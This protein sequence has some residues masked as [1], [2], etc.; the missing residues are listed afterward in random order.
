MTK[1]TYSEAV[2]QALNGKGS[3]ADCFLRTADGKL[4]LQFDS[5]VYER[6]LGP[7]DAVT[8]LFKWR[9]NVA[10]SYQQISLGP[11]TAVSVDGFEAR[12]KVIVG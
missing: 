5:I 7:I 1:P 2:V 3:A 9:G 8:I 4:H 12:M 6:D 11:N 10:W